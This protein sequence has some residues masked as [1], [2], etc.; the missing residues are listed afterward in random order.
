MFTNDRRRF[1]T[2]PETVPVM[3][4]W[5]ETWFQVLAVCW[6]PLRASGDWIASLG[7]SGSFGLARPPPEPPPS[8]S[9]SFISP[10]HR[11]LIA[12]VIIESWSHHF[13]CAIMNINSWCLDNVAI[14]HPLSCTTMIIEGWCFY[15][16]A[17]STAA[18]CIGAVKDGID[19]VHMEEDE[20][21]H[22]LDFLE[23]ADFTTGVAS[24]VD[25][26]CMHTVDPL[27]AV[28]VG[29]GTATAT[30]NGRICM[31]DDI[32]TAEDVGMVGEIQLERGRD[33][34]VGSIASLG[35]YCEEASIAA[36]NLSLYDGVYYEGARSTAVLNSFISVMDVITILEHIPPLIPF[37]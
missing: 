11:L 14:S 35:W 13:L 9:P 17:R 37:L 5:L 8:C 20:P 30:Q 36:L 28:D 19:G 2:R 31:V 12:P 16:T 25:E 27:V 15:V 22:K 23:A 29:I 4:P 18:R 34:D 24:L 21:M 26:D 7:V 1:V 32:V 6:F 10:Y 3:A 33:D